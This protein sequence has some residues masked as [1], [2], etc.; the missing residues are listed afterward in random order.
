MR[1]A[2]LQPRLHRQIGHQAEARDPFGEPHRP[3]LHFTPPHGWMNDPNGLVFAGG[4]Y[5]LYYQYN[6]YGRDWGTI[7][8]GHARS[9][10]LLRWE[11]RPIA[12]APD[13]DRL[14]DVASGS[15]V[16]DHT[17]SSGFGAPGGPPPVVAL[18]TNFPPGRRQVQSLAYSRDDGETW[19][20]YGH[21]PIIEN[22]GIDDFRDPKVIRYRDHWVMVL[23]ADD[24][25]RFYTSPD[26]IRW[27]HTQSFG[28][29]G[30][31]GSPWECPDLVRL[32]ADTWMLIVSVQREAP[33]GGSGIQYFLG[34]FDGAQFDCRPQ[35]EPRWLGYGP[36][37]YAAVTFSNVDHPIL[38]GW[39]SNWSYGRTAPTS[40]WRGA[41]G[42]P[43]RLS[44]T[45]DGTR[46]CQLPVEG[47]ADLRAAPIELPGP[48]VTPAELVLDV[49]PGS[50]I[51][52]ENASGEKLEILTTEAEVVLDRTRARARASAM[53]R[54][55]RAPF[56]PGP[57]RILVDVSSIEIFVGDG[58]SSL[59]ALYYTEQ[60][61]DVV[62][63]AGPVTGRAWSLAHA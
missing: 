61:L 13:F 22:P 48:C 49:D 31:Y 57:V 19:T 27:A 59:T 26:L 21:N 53:T 4:H 28:G 9:R 34:G 30:V 37:H 56:V 58:A 52:L 18:Y 55:A 51:E 2:M 54:T 42:T 8:W 32:D 38:M 63:L 20:E 35:T 36:D 16:V 3:R 41:M 40:P 1:R 14:G 60:P 15:A 10:D 17:N 62:T 11:H 23:A 43:R 46:V 29:V 5:H 39:M 47:H 12:L 50:R 33:N 24:V 44:L 45:A 7:H 6:P 25:I